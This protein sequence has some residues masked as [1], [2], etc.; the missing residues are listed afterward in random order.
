MYKRMHGNM[1]P[2]GVA[3]LL[4]KPWVINALARYFLVLLMAK[5]GMR[6]IC[7]FVLAGTFGTYDDNVM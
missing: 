1:P 3:L 4:V 2:A 6:S 5:I 7:A